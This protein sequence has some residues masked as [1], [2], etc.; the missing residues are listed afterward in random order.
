MQTAHIVE[1]QASI[2][3]VKLTPCDVKRART[4]QASRNNSIDKRVMPNAS[5]NNEQ[6][7]P[8][9]QLHA[10]DARGSPWSHGPDVW[11][12]SGLGSWSRVGHVLYVIRALHQERCAEPHRSTKGV[13]HSTRCVRPVGH[14][15]TVRSQRPS[16][17]Y[18]RRCARD[19]EST[20]Q[21]PSKW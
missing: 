11:P 5:N 21:E 15:H 6:N 14:G 19:S 1:D 4:H 12:H 17:S 8:S 7:N 16:A 10:A 20:P 18:L 3:N 9:R 13:G 2:R